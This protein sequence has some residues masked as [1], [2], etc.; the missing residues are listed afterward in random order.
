MSENKNHWLLYDG[1]CRFCLG[2]VNRWRGAL[3]CRGFGFAARQ[4]GWVRERLDLPEEELLREMRVLTPCGKVLGAADAFVFLWGKIWW[5]WPLWI[6]AHIPGARWLI[7]RA[8]SWV[9]AHRNCLGGACSLHDHTDTGR[10]G[11]RGAAPGWLPL[12]VF[13]ALVIGLK[14]LFAEPWIFMWALALVLFITCKWLTLWLAWA[15]G[16]V[17]GIRRAL[18][19]LFL[20]PG[21][22]VK[23][24]TCDG[25][26][27]D[28]PA[29]R[30]WL[31]P[32]AKTALGAVLIW[33][34][35]PLEI[36]NPVLEGW[37]GMIGLILMLHFG[38][39][40]LLALAWRARGVAAEPIMDSPVSSTSLS[41]F[42]S[43]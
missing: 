33:G 23:P 13:P 34:L 17:I 41:R 24:F 4:E 37:C 31:A 40:H 16:A 32:L 11:V 43:E 38:S 5:C 1:T 7:N 9:A 28:S 29:G 30:E 39:F 6:L 8:Y 3:E 36:E 25:E 21:M 10:P 20:W 14:D 12:A 18:A 27:A 2:M 35:G 19:Y 22:D 26:A 42:W 15:R